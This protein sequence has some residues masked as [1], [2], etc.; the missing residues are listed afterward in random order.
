[1]RRTQYHRDARLPGSARED[2]CFALVE[3]T[4]S[5]IARLTKSHADEVA[6][7]KNVSAGLN[8]VAAG[9]PWQ[10]GDTVVRCPELEHSNNIYGWLNRR[11]RGVKVRLV[12]RGATVFHRCLSQ[13]GRRLRAR[14]DPPQR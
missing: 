5:C 14:G 7:T 10:A 13:S 11:Y 2:E 4:R 8:T 1:M 6:L 12:S 3:R 9:M